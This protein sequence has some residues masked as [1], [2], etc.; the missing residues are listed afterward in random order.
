VPAAA[1]PRPS[2]DRVGDVPAELGRGG[3]VVQ[4]AH[5]GLGV[6]RVAEPDARLGRGHDPV[7][8]LGPDGRLTTPTTP[9]GTRWAR[10]LRSAET[11]AGRAP[12]SRFPSSAAMYLACGISGAI[13]HM[14]GCLSAKHIV[15]VN[16]DPDAPIISH[17]DYAVIGDLNQVLPALVA[18]IR[19]R[20]GSS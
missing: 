20:E 14:A 11:D 13:Q 8:E 5:G 15:A 6:E 4:R 19:A 18:A 1:D 17:A 12:A 16:T 3:L 10:I 9:S 7:G 2:C